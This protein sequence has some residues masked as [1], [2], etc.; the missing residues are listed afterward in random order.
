MQN[1]SKGEKARPGDLPGGGSKMDAGKV[2][3]FKGLIG[4]FPRACEQVAAVSA[5]GASKYDWNGW[6]KVPDGEERYMDGLMRH[7]KAIAVDGNF[8]VTDSELPHLAQ[9]AWNALAILEMKM[10]SGEIPLTQRTY[11]KP[12]TDETYHVDDYQWTASQLAEF[13][14]MKAKPQTIN[15]LATMEEAK[16]HG[17]RTKRGPTF[18]EDMDAYMDGSDKKI[19]PGPFGEDLED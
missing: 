12:V 2:P 11:V 16:E 10:R 17:A 13:E 6:E 14:A 15:K 8:D 9:I 5:Y 1:S 4:Y 3:I 18:A 7:V 19:R